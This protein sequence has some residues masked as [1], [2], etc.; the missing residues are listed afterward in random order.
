MRNSKGKN[1]I[2]ALQSDKF[3]NMPAESVGQNL[4]IFAWNIY[5]CIVQL[6]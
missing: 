6:Q 5:K 2:T 3:N 4:F 1:L